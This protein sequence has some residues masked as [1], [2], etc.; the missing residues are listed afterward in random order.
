MKE[1]FGITGKVVFN[2][3]TE[4]PSPKQSDI[5]LKLNDGDT[6]GVFEYSN[7]AEVINGINNPTDYPIL[8]H[9][10]VVLREKTDKSLYVEEISLNNY[11][12]QPS[13]YFGGM[14]QEEKNL[15]IQGDIIKK[16]WLD[17]SLKQPCIECDD[18]V[19]DKIL[20]G[21]SSARANAIE[22]TILNPIEHT[23][24]YAL[25]L[26]IKSV[27]GDPKGNSEVTYKVDISEDNQV[28]SGGDLFFGE[29]DEPSYEYQIVLIQQDGLV[30]TS[31]WILA[32]ALDLVIGS[33]IMDQ[34]FTDEG[35]D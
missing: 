1:R 22:V 11:E 14:T 24:A 12:V 2:P 6:Y 16:I 34:Y 35:E 3:F 26:Y 25:K 4:E 21:T 31:E 23:D 19:E 17:Y 29:S 10:L 8:L 27:Q 9:H 20:S 15:L 30:L 28:L 32:T 33:A 7:A 13:E 5:V 18:L